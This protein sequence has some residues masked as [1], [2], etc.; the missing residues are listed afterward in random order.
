VTICY[1]YE[2]NE[3]EFRTAFLKT[4]EKHPRTSLEIGK[5]FLDILGKRL[6]VS[7]LA[8]FKNSFVVDLNA[9]IYELSLKGEERTYYRSLAGYYFGKHRTKKS[10]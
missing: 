6:A 5:R 4:R 10:A 2:I 3:D 9:T 1:V 8:G 7:R